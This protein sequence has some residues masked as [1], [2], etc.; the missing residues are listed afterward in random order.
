MEY[1]KKKNMIVLT[2]DEMTRLFKKEKLKEISFEMA[3]S[4]YSFDELAADKTK[5][6]QIIDAIDTKSR[7]DT[8]QVE[9]FFA[10]FYF[11][12]FY[13]EGSR[14][15][16]IMKENYDLHKTPKTF[17]EL[18]NN[19]KENDLTDFSIVTPDYKLRQFQLK[20]YHKR[21]NG[22]LTTNDL[23]KFIKSIAE[24]YAFDFGEINLL[25]ILQKDGDLDDVDFDK[26]C[27]KIK[28][29][30]IKSRS[31]ILLTFN[32]NN[33]YNVIVRVFPKT[34]I[35]KVLRKPLLT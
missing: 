23:Y 27:V 18:K 15:G 29:I 22:N 6:H 17:E 5:A 20:Q 14:T 21:Y 33:Q 13:P 30:G 12:Q 1:L 9:L 35:Q 32:E 4:G 34:A 28:G 16:W 3:K 31:D 10:L 7:N 2:K 11:F 19:L 24:K 8:T 25:I 26:L